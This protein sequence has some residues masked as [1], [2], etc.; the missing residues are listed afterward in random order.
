[1]HKSSFAEWTKLPVREGT[2]LA[3]ETHLEDGFLT[4]ASHV[5]VSIEGVVKRA[6]RERVSMIL[7]G[8]HIHPGLTQN[9]K[10]ESDVLMIP[11]ML[12]VVKRKR[13]KKRLEGR[14]YQVSMRRSERYLENFD[15]IWRLQD[16]LLSEADQYDVPIIPNDDYEDSIQLIMETISEVLEEEFK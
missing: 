1:L 16:Y 12:A 4:Q 13:L 3:Y 7:E 14:G 5:A 11:L 2:E 8:V 9:L 15:A 10:F 6:E